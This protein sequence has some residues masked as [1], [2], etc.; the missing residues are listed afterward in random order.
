MFYILC[1]VAFLDMEEL[2][3]IEKY[4]KRIEHCKKERKECFKHQDRDKYIRLE[5]KIIVYELVIAD[6]NNT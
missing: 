2:K 6:L 4:K 3:L 5:G 1:Y